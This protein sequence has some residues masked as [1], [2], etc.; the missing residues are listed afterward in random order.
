MTK[1][2][3]TVFVLVS[4]L[5]AFS[6]TDLETRAK[7]I[8]DEGKMLYRL[9][10]AAWHGS[11]IFKTSYKEPWHIGGYFAY[12]DEDKPKCLFFSKAE[13][14]K[15][16]GV[17]SFGD[18]IVVETATIA[19]KEREF[20]NK[21][22]ELYTIRAKAFEEVQTDTLF[23]AYNNTNLNLIPLIYNGEKKVYAIT[24]PK[25][26]GTV[27]FGNDY[28]FAFGKN[29]SL[30]EKKQIHRNLIPI[31]FDNNK[32]TIATVH[33][34]ASE[35]G[36]FI[37]PTDICTLMLYSKFTKWKTHYVVSENYVSIWDCE[38]EELTILTREDYDKQL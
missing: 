7:E 23:K 27:L 13:K 18:M 34:H 17:V 2:I 10:I 5:S 8:S 9:E 36:E 38:K 1:L 32:E 35:T 22:Q 25:V 3:L 24:A 12:M 31:E 33:Y 21:E 28:L 30:I 11:D 16:I 15:V 19:F 26:V 20:S 4:S 6:Q 14:P 37:T 29:N